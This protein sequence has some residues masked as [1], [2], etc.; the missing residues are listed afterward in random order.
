[1]LQKEEAWYCLDFKFD[2][3]DLVYGIACG[4]MGYIMCIW[5]GGLTLYTKD[6]EDLLVSFTM[7]C[8]CY[9]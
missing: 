8:I 2:V 6:L 1:M 9:V 4:V 7:D 3:C 5:A